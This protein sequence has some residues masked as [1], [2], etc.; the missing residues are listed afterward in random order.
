MSTVL[1]NLV[2]QF[3]IPGGLLFKSSLNCAAT[4]GFKYTSKEKVK[5]KATLCPKIL[6]K[7]GPVNVRKHCDILRTLKSS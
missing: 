4:L 3:N 5:L 7:S 2:I 6:V 1:E